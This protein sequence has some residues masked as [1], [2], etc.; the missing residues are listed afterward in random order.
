MTAAQEDWAGMMDDLDDATA[1]LVLQCQLDDIQ[2]LEDAATDAGAGDQ[3]VA[4]QFLRDELEEYRALR[5]TA[6]PTDDEEVGAGAPPEPEAPPTEP[7]APLPEP[8]APTPELE[9]PQTT[10][11]PQPSIVNSSPATPTA[12]GFF[13]CVAVRIKNVFRNKNAAPSPPAPSTPV[14]TLPPTPT[15]PLVEPPMGPTFT[16]EACGDRFS[17]AHCWQAPCQH[18]YCDEDLGQ[19]FRAS[20]IDRALYPPRCCRQAMPFEDVQPFLVPELAQ[21]FAAK[22]E[23]LDERQ[24]T[25]CHVPTCST[26]L[27]QAAKEDTKATCPSCGEETCVLCKQTNHI[28]D[29]AEDETLRQTQ[30]LAREQGWQRCID[31]QRYVELNVGCNHMT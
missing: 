15:P 28:G 18:W 24:P 14:L 25:Y 10:Q 11:M 26:Y 27:G 1:R 31:C 16:C 5:P 9:A 20:M 21:D 2:A 22:K 13:A 12:G 19:L 29:C 23:E 17:E 7:E 3:Q 8:E 30:E 6:S 4:L